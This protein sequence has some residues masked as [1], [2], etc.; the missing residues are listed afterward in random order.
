MYRST[1]TYDHSIGISAAFRQWRAT[2]SHCS[3]LHGY[4]LKFHFEF[5]STTLD[6]RNWV[7]DFGGLDFVKQ[8]LQENFDHKT[9][10]ASDDPQLEWFKEAE[11]RGILQLTI[12]PN[13]GCEKFAEEI[14]NMVTTAL[15]QK[16]P[17]RA[18]TVKLT[19]VTVAEHTANSAS[20]LPDHPREIV[21][22]NQPD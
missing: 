14:Y 19:L 6:S 1:K 7:I 2:H 16:F 8:L 4:A 21:Y 22:I 15:A 3:F 11:K 9:V 17:E 20:Y 18:K 10:V 5:E 13:V 12:I